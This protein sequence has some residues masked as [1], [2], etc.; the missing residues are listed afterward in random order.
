MQENKINVDLQMN[1]HY[2]NYTTLLENKTNA[3]LQMNLSFFSISYT[4]GKNILKST[5]YEV[6]IPNTWH[7]FRR[8]NANLKFLFFGSRYFLSQSNHFYSKPKYTHSINVQ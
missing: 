7:S 2:W 4:T 1:L 8:H 5:I 3:D 6:Y